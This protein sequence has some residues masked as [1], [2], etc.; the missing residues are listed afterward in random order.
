MY[1]HRHLANLA[2]VHELYVADL[3]KSEPGIGEGGM[4]LP[5][6]PAYTDEFSDMTKYKCD[7][8]TNEVLPTS[9]FWRVIYG[10]PI[11]RSEISYDSGEGC[12]SHRNYVKKG[13]ERGCRIQ[14]YDIP[15]N[16]NDPKAASPILT[17]FIEKLR[18]HVFWF[19]PWWGELDHNTTGNCKS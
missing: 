1:I 13:L 8:L 9:N 14:N 15:T 5:R 19:G 17:D 16:P 10:D 18:T 11:W 7:D 2:S 12:T 3:A 6:K 4:K